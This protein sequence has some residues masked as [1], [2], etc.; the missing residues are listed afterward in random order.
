M[1]DLVILVADRNMEFGV[2][3]LLSQNTA[4]GL[5]QFAYDT[6]VHP[7]RDSGCLLRAHDFLRP[8][9]RRYMN[10]LVMLDREGCG[11]EQVSRRTL[12]QQV[13]G[14]LAANGWDDRAAAIIFDPELESWVWSDSP[15][16]DAILGWARRQPGLRTWLVTEGYTDHPH[17]KPSRP[18]EAVEKAL[19]LSHK[20]RSSSLYLRLGT[21]VTF[22]RCSDPAFAKFKATLGKWFGR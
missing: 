22:D 2:K 13:E 7:Q 17:A 16:V 21:S 9:L 1:K 19:R 10:A 11:Q 3:G 18:K 8:F 4:L 6:Y 15:H 12:E 14:L 20:P 5:R